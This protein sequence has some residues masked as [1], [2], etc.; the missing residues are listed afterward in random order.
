MVRSRA[1]RWC[2]MIAATS[3]YK[4]GCDSDTTKKTGKGVAPAANIEKPCKKI[5]KENE[6]W[7]ITA[8]PPRKRCVGRGSPIYWGSEDPGRDA[9]DAL[10]A[11]SASWAGAE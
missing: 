1:P 11:A 8:H 2:D 7:P 9:G 4:R 5:G 3:R 6:L 10:V